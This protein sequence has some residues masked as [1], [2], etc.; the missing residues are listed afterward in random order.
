MPCP[1]CSAP[2][3]DLLPIVWEG[4]R[5]SGPFW[6][7]AEI[8][9]LMGFDPWTIQP[10]ASR[11]TNYRTMILPGLSCG[12]ETWQLTLREERRLRVLQNR[13]LWHMLGEDKFM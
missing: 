3:N 9:L 1:R 2:R 5:A 8:F 4:G 11:Y 7:G 12:C 6:A 10:I 13:E